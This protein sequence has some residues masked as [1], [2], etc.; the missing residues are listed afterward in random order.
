[1]SDLVGTTDESLSERVGVPL[2][3]TR[4]LQLE[5]AVGR[6]QLRD[7]REGAPGAIFSDASSDEIS[8]R[9]RAGRE[10]SL[11]K[12][13]LGKDPDVRVVDATAGLGRDVFVLAHNGCHVTAIEGNRV[14]AA[15]L[16]D[17]AHR[18][19]VETLT[20]VEGDSLELMS[21]HANG[22]VVYLDPMFPGR[23]KSA[24]VKKEMQ[25]LQLLELPE[26]NPL[27]LLEAARD[28]GA[29]K[30]VMK[31]PAKSAPVAIKPNHSIGGKTVR[32]DV[33]I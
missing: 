20:V 28:A 9:V 24:A 17:A 13:I 1:M 30:V 3:A 5:Y 2:D 7:I 8:R 12:A 33:Y 26:S 11:V 32:F 23:S 15:L 25:Y 10:L 31:R 29:A 22:A 18:A 4:P 14:V 16:A 27:I 19:G 21:E 6:L